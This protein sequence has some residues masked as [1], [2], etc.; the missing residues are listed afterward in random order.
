VALRDGRL[1][2]EASLGHGEPDTEPGIGTAASSGADRTV[3][4]S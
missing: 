2:H 1:D 3:A 4:R